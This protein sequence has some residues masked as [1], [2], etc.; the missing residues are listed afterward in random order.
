MKASMKLIC[1]VLGTLTSSQKK[2]SPNF[3][4]NGK[5]IFFLTTFC[6]FGCSTKTMKFEMSSTSTNQEI[7]M[8]RHIWDPQTLRNYTNSTNNLQTK[9]V[10]MGP[11]QREWQLIEFQTKSVSVQGKITFETHSWRFYIY[12]SPCWWK[13]DGF[14]VIKVQGQNVGRPGVPKAFFGC[15]HK[16]TVRTKHFLMLFHCDRII[17]SLYEAD[18]KYP[19]FTFRL[20][21]TRPVRSW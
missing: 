9:I 12:V 16:Q 20:E 21:E 11:T 18:F 15:R 3:K 10:D 7:L 5:R 8:K 4:L 14:R 6:F 17:L 2:G 19:K 13:G 1:S